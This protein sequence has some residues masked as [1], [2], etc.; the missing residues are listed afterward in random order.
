[1]AGPDKVISKENTHPI[2]ALVS[3]IT[4]CHN[5]SEFISQTID[6]V[7]AQTYGNWEMIIVD[8]CSTDST[9]QIVED[10]L[11]KDSRIRL[12]R[13]GR[14]CGPAVARNRAIE[15]ARGRYIAFLDSDDIW[16]PEKLEKQT[17]FM[18]ENDVDL[19]YSSYYI[20]DESGSEKGVFITKEKATYWDLLKTCCIGNLTAIY[21]AEKLGKQYM[22]DVGHQDYTLWLRI[23]KGGATAR[24]ILEPLAKYRIRSKSISSNKIKAARWQ[25]HIYRNVER[26]SLLQSVYYFAHY[27]YNGSIKHLLK[28]RRKKVVTDDIV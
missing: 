9:V 28:Y 15:E 5:S 23:L 18:R 20:I 27:A 8:D 3:I 6:S 19:C 10:Y 21:D 7:L 12:I 13:L 17:A 25:W 24:G 2:T 26:L 1:M 4:P 14:N 16:L 11:K 22:E